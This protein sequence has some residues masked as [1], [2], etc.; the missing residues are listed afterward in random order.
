[1]S[2]NISFHPLFVILCCVFAYYGYVSLLCSYLVCL[3]LHEFAHSFMAFRLGYK[4][5]HIKVMPHG[6]SIGGNNMYFSY[7]DEISI[8]I[9]GPL[10][11]F[12]LAMLVLSV[13]W[14]WP[15]SYVYTLDF[16]VA[17]LV[18]GLVNLLPV[19][20][21]DGGRILLALLSLRASRLL[22]VKIMR[23]IGVVISTAILVGFVATTFFVP[24]F[25]MLFFGL[26]LFVTTLCDTR[27]IGYMRINNLE[28]K[29]SRINKG[30]AVRNIAVNPDITLY[31]LFAQISPFS[32][33]NF[34]II[35]NDMRVVG[36]LNEKQLNHL[37]T[38]YPANVRLRVILP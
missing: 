23:I 38:I 10:A 30:I 20:P 14:L 21:L 28:Y 19:Y 27:N 8:A 31:K 4:L 9:V 34:T 17:N 22:A 7:R 25:T 29:L 33:T 32:I 18:I 5:N 24:N 26:F 3:M 35:D 2:W 15:V 36:Q 12:A 11:N 16:F 1:M 37:V 13:W 6:V